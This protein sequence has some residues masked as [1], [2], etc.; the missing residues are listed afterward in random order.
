MDTRGYGPSWL[1]LSHGTRATSVQAG[2]GIRGN[3]QSARRSPEP[4]STLDGQ[5]NGTKPQ[6]DSFTHRHTLT[7]PPD[8]ENNALWI[9]ATKPL[10]QTPLFSIHSLR[11]PSPCSRSCVHRGLHQAVQKRL[12]RIRHAVPMR[13]GGTI[14]CTHPHPLPLSPPHKRTVLIPNTV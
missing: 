2:R 11:G 3:P 7:Q 5:R 13:H 6:K 9:E 4:K 1:T 10:T 14:T 8:G 12:N